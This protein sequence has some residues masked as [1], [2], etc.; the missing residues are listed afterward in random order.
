MEKE[1]KLEGNSALVLKN[2]R[3]DKNHSKLCCK[4]QY[5]LKSI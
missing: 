4:Y 2:C 3:N 5:R 1:S